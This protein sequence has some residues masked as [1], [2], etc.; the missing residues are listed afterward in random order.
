[1]R[2]LQI[3]REPTPVIENFLQA[4]LLDHLKMSLRQSV[5]TYQSGVVSTRDNI[6]G[7]ESDAEE[8]ALVED[9]RE[10]VQYNEDGLEDLDRT[11]S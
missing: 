5:P 10:Q 7:D 2:T 6:P 4:L 8:D 9:Y 11:Q 3:L 1:V